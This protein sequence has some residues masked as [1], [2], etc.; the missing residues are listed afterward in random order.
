MKHSDYIEIAR[1]LGV[2]VLQKSIIGGVVKAAPFFAVGLP[3]TILIK[4]ATWLA[5]IIA[6]QAEMMIFFKY[7]DLRTDK[8]ASD[9]EAAMIKNHQ[10]QLTG[11]EQEKKDAEKILAEALNRLVNLKS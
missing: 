9:F 11:T 7:I 10:A 4:F 1:G 2:K 6:D 3:N 8:Q 5:G